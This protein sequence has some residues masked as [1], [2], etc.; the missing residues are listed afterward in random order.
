[1][2]TPGVFTP[3]S[4]VAPFLTV[5]PSWVD[6]FEQQRVAS[7][8]K[9][10]EIYWASE[11]GFI[12]LLRG[13]NEQPVLMPTGRTLVNTV[14]RFTGSGFG[15]LISGPDPSSVQVAQMAFARLFDR[16]AF[17]SKYNSAKRY[18]LIRGDW[19]WHVVANPG[20]PEGRRLSLEIVDP[21]AYFP[22]WD[23]ADPTR[24]VKVHLAEQLVEGD[25][26]FVSRLTYEKDPETG[27]IWRS[28]GVF[29]ME[30]WWNLTTPTRVILPREELPVE[31]TSIPVY[32]L[33][34]FDP[35]APFGSSELRG[36]ESVLL[37]INQT[38][39]DESLTLATEGLGQYATDGGPPRDET[40]AE[41]DVIGGPGRVLYNAA[42]L[43]RLNGTTSVV[44]YGDHYDRLRAAAEASLGVSP[45]AV[46]QVTNEE[47][48]SGVALALRMAP[49]LA[50]VAEK[51]DT[52]RDVHRQFFHDLCI[53][54]AVYDGLTVLITN[55]EGGV[56]VTVAVLP[57]F[58]DKLPKNQ[59]QAIHD[60]VELRSTVPPIISLRTAH[61][62]LRAAGIHIDD[63]ELELLVAE[64][65]G[66][67]DPLAEPTAEDEQEMSD[68]LEREAAGA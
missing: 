19:L 17:H 57:T 31:I 54:M 1:M 58:G 9:Y 26:T 34:N 18:W 23:E 4:T 16:E 10:E 47:A 38:L 67:F 6:P 8:Q 44:P 3:Y 5:L 21:G 45:T 48:E 22:V 12:E 65:S 43:R 53:W 55:V 14:N 27:R 52:I 28:H 2:T 42:G 25:K 24:V 59:A 50:G 13:D 20:K 61:E 32:H 37:D 66:N 41:V 64:A 40:G 60:V 68:R 63:R 30:D 15:Y 29:D 33:K 51:D 7:Y 49:L 11:E 39:S 36:L 46:G 35:T 56:Q 62:M